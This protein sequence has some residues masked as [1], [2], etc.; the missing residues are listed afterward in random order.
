MYKSVEIFLADWE[1]ESAGTAKVMEALTD[2][3]LHQSVADDHRTLGR[4]AWHIVTTIPE[5]ME[6][7][8]VE[9]SCVDPEADVPETAE[10]VASAYR[11][12][13]QALA[14]F[15]KESWTDETLQVEDNLYGQTWKRGM[16]LAALHRHEIHHRGQMTVL[17]RQAGLRVPGVYGPAKEDWKKLG[18]KPPAI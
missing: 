15:L 5:M 17:M 7:V 1:R 16:T 6:H 14:A 8:G 13:A 12:A 9:L 3:S 10:A 11:E 18:T 4:I 2:E